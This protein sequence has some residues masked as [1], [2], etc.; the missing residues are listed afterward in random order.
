[1]KPDFIILDEPTRGIDVGA[2]KEIEDLIKEISGQGIS[3]LLISSEFEELIR[4][5]DRVEV[6]RDG[7]NAGCLKGEEITE[8][9]I[10]SLIANGKVD[11]GGGISA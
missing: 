5:C 6:L 10:M 7:R 1:M 4:N 3:I 11:E 8:N 9:N 2:K